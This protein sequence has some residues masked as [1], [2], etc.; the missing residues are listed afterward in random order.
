[1]VRCCALALFF[2]NARLLPGSF[3]TRV[4]A[5][6]ALQTFVALHIYQMHGL[7]EMHF[8]F[9]TAFTM[10]IVYQDWLCMWPGTLLII[11]QHILFALLHNA[12][13]QLYFFEVD[14]ITFMRLVFHFGIA[15]DARRAS[16]ATGRVLLR[17][18]T[19]TDAGQR[20]A[21][22]RAARG[23]GRGARPGA[24]RH[25]R[26]ERVPGDDEPRD[27]HADERRDRA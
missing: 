1:M 9:F 26:Q 25:A 19:L 21:A 8:W 23:A 12:G 4:A 14:Y 2:V 20:A 17:R 13:Y 10:M 24:R 3:A 11:G 18:E 22:A 7:A 6:I 15:V 16:A 5:G 27:P